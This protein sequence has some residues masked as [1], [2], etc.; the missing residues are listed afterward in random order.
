MLIDLVKVCQN[1]GKG[2]AWVG[3]GSGL[4]DDGEAELDVGVL[5]K[6]VESAL[7]EGVTDVWSVVGSRV[8]EDGGDNDVDEAEIAEA[9]SLGRAQNCLRLSASYS[10]QS[11]SPKS[12][13]VTPPTQGPNTPLPK[14]SDI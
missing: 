4:A 11:P 7:E 5:E 10:F 3:A 8:A 1:N 13:S 9:L 12:Q 14:V 2:L 6:V